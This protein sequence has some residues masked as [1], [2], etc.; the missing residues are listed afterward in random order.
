MDDEFT[1]KTQAKKLEAE[2]DNALQQL[3]AA[4][5][6]LTEVERQCNLF[7]CDFDRTA[8]LE[9]ALGETQ[10]RF[11]KERAEH[12]RTKIA[13]EKARGDLITKTQEAD[14]LLTHSRLTARAAKLALRSTKSDDHRFALEDILE[15]FN[16]LPGIAANAATLDAET[17]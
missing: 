13:A 10:E 5:S 15:A 11:T 16:A 17:V 3:E 2:R 6:R 4:Q 1:W 14:L 9:R 8:E 7:K 12:A